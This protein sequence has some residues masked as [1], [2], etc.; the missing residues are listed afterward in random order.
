M[1]NFLKDLNLSCDAVKVHLV[2]NLAFLKNLDSYFFIGNS[3]YSQLDLAESSFTQSF[4]D[5]EIT[6]FLSLL[7]LRL[8]AWT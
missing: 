5:Q 6:D 4:V 3:L 7:R 8:R 1:P 2:L